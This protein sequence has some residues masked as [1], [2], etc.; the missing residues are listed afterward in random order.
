[1]AD[2]CFG[3][4]I[5]ALCPLNPD[6]Q[7]RRAVRAYFATVEE[8]LREAIAEY[9]QIGRLINFATN[10]FMSRQGLPSAQNWFVPWWLVGGGIGFAVCV[11]L[12]SGWYR[13]ARAA[14][15]DPVEALRYQ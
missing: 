4:L 11:S 15:L 3:V 5:L 14:R 6:H 13:A 12:V 10:V 8:R 2:A 7:K 9:P 1:V